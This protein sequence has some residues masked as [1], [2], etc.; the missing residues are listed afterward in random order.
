MTTKRNWYLKVK[1]AAEAA[2]KKT[3]EDQQ[4]LSE[5]IKNEEEK[6]DRWLD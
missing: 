1:A 3:K 6:Q 4:S 2:A 5:F